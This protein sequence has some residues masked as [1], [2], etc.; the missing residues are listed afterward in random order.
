MAETSQMEGAEMTQV[1]LV[2]EDG[3]L[4]EGL[5]Q[6]LA[7]QG[8]APAVARS[9][10]EAHDLCVARPPL[11][12]VADRALASSGGVEL[13]GVPLAAGGVR[14][15]YHTSTVALPP[16]LP[17]LQRAVLADLTLPLERH[18]LAALIQSVS[19]RSRL[20]GRATRQTPTEGR[21]I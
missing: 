19:E 1:T 17:A 4:L 5:S 8:H 11:V 9:L 20:T 6:A 15:L 16:L 7:A 2:G 3:A 18:R 10:G 12:L 21:V 14:V 13:L